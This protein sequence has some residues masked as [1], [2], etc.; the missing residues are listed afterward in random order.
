MVTAQDKALAVLCVERGL[1]DDAAID[2]ARLAHAEALE[3][4]GAPPLGQ[5]LVQ[6][7]FLNPRLAS[8]LLRELALSA[9]KCNKCSRT[10]TYEDLAKLGRYRCDTCGERLIR[11]L[12]SPTGRPSSTGRPHVAEA[13]RTEVGPG[14]ITRGSSMSRGSDPVPS[15]V[16]VPVATHALRQTPGPNGGDNVLQPGMQIGPYQILNELGRGA[17]GVVYLAR[18]PGLERL[19]AVKLLLGG[20]LADQEAVERFRREAALASRIQHPSIVS[21]CDVGVVN[22]LHY[23]VMDYCA[24]RTLKAVF[25]EKKRYPWEEAVRL[26]LEISRGVAAAHALGIVHRDVKPANVI[27]DAKTDAPKIMDFGLARDAASSDVGMTRTGDIVGTPS[28]SAPEQLTGKKDVDARIDVYALGVILY[29][30]ISGVRPH[31]AD[32]VAHLAA[33]VLTETPKALRERVPEVPIAIEAIVSKATAKRADDRYRTAK[34]LADDIDRFLAGQP[35]T[36]RAE[37][38]VSRFWRRRKRVVAGVLLGGAVIALGAGGFL[39]R[40]LKDAEAQTRKDLANIERNAGGRAVVAEISSAYAA[41]ALTS[42]GSLAPEVELSWAAFA[43]RRGLPEVSIE[44]ARPLIGLAGSQGLEAKRLLADGLCRFGRRDEAAPVLE[45][46]EHAGDPVLQDWAR[47]RRF[48]G[49]RETLPADV[50]EARDR[51]FAGKDPSSFLLV[52]EIAALD[53]DA[54]TEKKALARTLELAADTVRALVLEAAW[55]RSGKTITEVRDKDKD[56]NARD[57]LDAAMRIGPPELAR[58]PLVAYVRG[59]TELSDLRVSEAR[60]DLDAALDGGVETPELYAFRGWFEDD[61]GRR[62]RARAEELLKDRAASFRPALG[63]EIQLLASLTPAAEKRLE[64]LAAG[65]PSAAR[66]PLAAAILASARG[67]P[68]DRVKELFDTASQ[69]GPGTDPVVVR[70]RARFLLSRGRLPDAVRLV[71]EQPATTDPELLLV[72]MEAQRRRGRYEDAYDL[73]KR[74]RALDSNG[75]CGFLAAAC[76]AVLDDDTDAGEYLDKAV[77]LAPEDGWARAARADSMGEGVNRTLDEARAAVGLQGKLDMETFVVYVKVKFATMPMP[78]RGRGRRDGRREGDRGEG[79]PRQRFG[80]MREVADAIVRD[81]P[82]TDH[83][84]FR[85][86]LAREEDQ[87]QFLDAARKAD[88]GSPL[89]EEALGFGALAD[90]QG[91]DLGGL[92]NGGGLPGAPLARKHFLA[93]REI[94]PR[95]WMS[96][97]PQLPIPQEYRGMANSVLSKALQPL[98]TEFARTRR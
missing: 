10:W 43:A 26:V 69:C 27:M 2:R 88:P 33:M 30:L 89:L 40:R 22:G 39:G 41:L 84:I 14:R 56:S 48:A 97:L 11:L 38:A 90:I 31:V 92:L 76:M 32:T 24:G 59:V 49:R 87:S 29:E 79:D 36:A 98:R 71:E 75:K 96:R 60:A 53:G 34:E 17:M 63:D 55:R 8:D 23:Y 46:L 83:F 95:W 81:S 42:P 25:Q 15:P 12:R 21:V 19:F 65:A 85:A 44:H 66:G 73:A 1:L 6:G 72:G 61:Q 35:V 86:G 45:E 4:G 52:A 80:Q 13:T 3:S 58:D 62:A 51:T 37:G 91:G 5:L 68:F 67:E 50:K 94:D 18:R 93:A 54:E 28:Y 74:V 16:M 64:G 7:G 78:G 70:E 77:Q 9:Y 47:L 20:L 82:S 57:E